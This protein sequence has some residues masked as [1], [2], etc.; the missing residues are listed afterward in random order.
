M[1]RLLRVSTFTPPLSDPFVPIA[2]STGK[3]SARTAGSN[4]SSST[5]SGYRGLENQLYHVEIH[6]VGAVFLTPTAPTFKWARNNASLFVAAQIESGAVTIQGSGQGSLLGLTVGQYV[7]LVD[8]PSEL[9]GQPGHLAQIKQVNDITGQLTVDPPPPDNLKQVRL[10]LWNGIG[11]I[12]ASQNASDAGWIPLEYGIE[13]Q[14]TQGDTYNSGD[15]WLIPARTATSQIEWSH[16]APQLPQGIRHHYVRLAYL[17]QSKTIWLAQDYRRHFF[18]LVSDALHV[19]DISWKNDVLNPRSLLKEGLSIVLDGEP[20]QDYAGAMQAAMIVSIESALPGGGAGT[21][22]ISGH[23]EI[24]AN[25]IRWHWH[26]EEREGLIAKFFAK[27]DDLHSDL[28]E[29][30]EHHQRVRV[31]LKGHYIWRTVNGRRYYLDGQT[32]GMPGFEQ[33]GYRPLQGK[34]AG[35]HIDLD[36]P[37]GIGRPTSDFESWFYLRE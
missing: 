21:L 29:K 24:N 30:H 22:I 37:S 34:E 16:T 7:E 9:L 6:Q 32:F 15:Y 31:T 35:R 23:F 13:I 36:F 20:D 14:F 28:F 18:P 1:N 26:R 2:F 27:F 4:G 10:R 8:E 3:L 33:S 11:S 12:D 5:T 17:L 25:T 19:L